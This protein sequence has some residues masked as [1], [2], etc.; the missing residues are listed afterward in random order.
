MRSNKILV[1]TL[2]FSAG[3]LT[4]IACRH[5]L[6]E[7]VTGG[8]GTGT[9]TGGGT[10]GTT[11]TCS[12]DTVY[13]VNDIMPII[14]SNCN[15]SGCHDNISH[16][17]GVNLTT[18][19]NIMRY[20]SAGNAANSKLYKVI[21]KTNGDRMPPPPMPPLTAAQKTKIEKWINQGAKNNSCASSCDTAI[22]TYAGAVKP[23]M[24]NKCVGCHNP[25]SLGG[26]I[27][28]STHSAVKVIALNG[29]LY[30]SVAHTT[31]FSPMPQNSAKLSDCEIRQIQKWVNAGSPNN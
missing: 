11:S 27:D 23:V 16:A 25:A 5:Q 24:D 10:G 9:G 17:D 30:G 12:A 15:L 29:K 31:G 2:L 7:D 14:S 28:V 3:L 20:V 6:T 1:A 22:F 13:F 18:Y 21:I 8:S 4:I 26:N 19:S